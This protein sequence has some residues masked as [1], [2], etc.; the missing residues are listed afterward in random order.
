MENSYEEHKR[1]TFDSFC[2]K[3]LKNELR[4]YYK[5]INK[6]R[7]REITFSELPDNE[8]SK[9]SVYDTYFK[10]THIFSVLNCDVIVND[11]SIIQALKNLPEHKRDIILLSYFLDMSDREIADKLN[12]V[13][14]TVQYRRKSILKELKKFMEGKYNE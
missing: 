1:H 11:E 12:M 5:E 14:S 4:N 10:D 9:L 8:I 3:M 6:R 13:R 2:K 7:M